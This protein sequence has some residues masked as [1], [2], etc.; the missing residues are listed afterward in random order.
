MA[1]EFT[2]KNADVYIS[3]IHVSIGLTQYC[4]RGHDLASV[5]VGNP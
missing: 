1:S 4:D 5:N 3:N 2:R